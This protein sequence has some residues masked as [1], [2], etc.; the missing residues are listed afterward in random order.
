M[1]TV[2]GNRGTQ[3]LSGMRTPGGR[4]LTFSPAARGVAVA[5]HPDEHCRTIATP[6]PKT[7]G[8]VEL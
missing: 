7:P 4:A 3:G 8:S 5:A 6:P 1:A 2:A